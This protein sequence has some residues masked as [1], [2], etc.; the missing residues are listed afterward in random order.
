MM[1]YYAKHRRNALA[2]SVAT[3]FSGAAVTAYAQTPTAASTE[4]LIRST[5]LGHQSELTMPIEPPHILEAYLKVKSHNWGNTTASAELNNELVFW[6]LAVKP[7][8]IA[9]MPGLG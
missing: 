5:Y 9:F 8:P 7:I 6:A 4:D 2:V 3:L 1:N